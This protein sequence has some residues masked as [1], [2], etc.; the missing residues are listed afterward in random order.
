MA[1]PEATFGPKP[2]EQEA[3]MDRLP[4]GCPRMPPTRMCAMVSCPRLKW[5]GMVMARHFWGANKGA[6]LV[7]HTDSDRHPPAMFVGPQ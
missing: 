5:K 6:A 3:C 4:R 7:R 2:M 1:M